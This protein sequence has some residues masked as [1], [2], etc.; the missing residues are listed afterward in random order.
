[1]NTEN[2]FERTNRENNENIKHLRTELNEKTKKI[3]ELTT[4]IK[5]TET[6]AEISNSRDL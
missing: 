3:E 1:M 5:S 2:E 4:N 6:N